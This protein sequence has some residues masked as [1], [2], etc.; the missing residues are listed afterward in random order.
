MK[1]FIKVHDIRLY[2]CAFSIVST[3]IYVRI[4]DVNEATKHDDEIKH[5][6]GI[7]KIILQSKFAQCSV[8]IPTQIK[9]IM[10]IKYD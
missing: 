5:V 2:N 3:H 9:L 6:P 8:L 7:P 1:D 10:Y 4:N